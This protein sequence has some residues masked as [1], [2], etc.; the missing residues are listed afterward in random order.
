MQYDFISN[1]NLGQITPSNWGLQIPFSYS[2]GETYITPKYDPFYQD[3][4]LD[5]RL[6]TAIRSTQKGFN[7]ESSYRLYKQKKYKFYWGQE[8]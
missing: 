3:L 7:K 2:N 4:K 5:D 1:I 8:K 6:D